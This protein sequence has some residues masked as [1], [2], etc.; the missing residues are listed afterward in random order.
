M[1]IHLVICY[2]C[3]RIKDGGLARFFDGGEVLSTSTKAEPQIVNCIK[4]GGT[5][6][7][8]MFTIDYKGTGTHG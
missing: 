8:F 2:S 1:K 6:S 3:D 4:C 7:K 5:K